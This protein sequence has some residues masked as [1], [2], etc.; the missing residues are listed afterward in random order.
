MGTWLAES[1]RAYVARRS[2]IINLVL[3]NL[4]LDGKKLTF[5][6]KK[7]FDTLLSQQ[8]GLLWLRRPDSNRRPIG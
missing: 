6:L 5:N 1:F 3:S 4:K 8:K 2:M 7:P